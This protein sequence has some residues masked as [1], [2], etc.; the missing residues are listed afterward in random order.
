M[1]SLEDKISNRQIFFIIFITLS[2][3]T[4]VEL[5]K[6]MAR[7]AGTGAWVPLLIAAV[8]FSFAVA[9]IIHLG[10]L[11]IGK[12]L[13]EYS[14]LLVGKF[15]TYCFTTI[16]ILYFFGV[17]SMLIR[18]GSEIVKLEILIKT[19]IWAT[20]LALILFSAFAASKGISNIGRI[21]EFFGYTVFLSIILLSIL[22]FQSGDTLNIFPLFEYKQVNTYIEALPVAIMP[23]LGIEVLTMIPISKCN[24][25]KAV[26][27]SI[28]GVLTVCAYY[29]LAVYLTYMLLGVEDTKNYKDS[30]FIGI[31]LLDIEMLQFLKRLDIV[32][33]T[34]WIYSMFCTITIVIYALYEYTHKIFSKAKSQKL[35]IVVCGLVY[36]AALLPASSDE[37]AQ[38]FTYLTMYFGLIPAFII[39]M[40]LLVTAKVKNYGKN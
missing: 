5:P 34:V 3:F 30:L 33:F 21:F 32:A 11:F 27:Y 15:V 1:I 31:R 9:V 4:I 22:M 10:N 7:S 12:T 14:T 35:F 39:P 29:I 37:A 26:F 24:E 25:R 6:T 17:L 28:C 40:I 36:I 38:I 13:F 2:S 20:G 16:Y 18:S 8:I 23:F 19:P